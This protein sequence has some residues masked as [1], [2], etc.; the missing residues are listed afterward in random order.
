MARY[1]GTVSTTR[2]IEN[3]FDYLAEF[4]NAAEW[5]PGV[6]G[7]ERLDAGPVRLGSVFR[8]HVRTGVRTSPFDYRIVEYQRPERVVLLGTHGSMRSEDTV[9][10]ET[11]TSG[12]T[13]LTYDADFRFTG[14]AS[15]ANPLL[16]V[17]FR[18]IA[19][20]GLAGL[21]RALTGADG[22]GADAAEALP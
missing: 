5:D 9:T 8:L 13:T 17:P 21:Q 3:A 11:A 7:A 4:S 14:V 10:F 19:D 16:A 6:T 15:L 1:R 12:G 18:R 20:R 22:A 2:S